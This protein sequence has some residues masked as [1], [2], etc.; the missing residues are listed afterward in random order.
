[1][2]FTSELKFEIEIS[3]NVIS[4]GNDEIVFDYVG[5]DMVTYGKQTM[6]RKIYHA[7]TVDSAS[8]VRVLVVHVPNGNDVFIPFRLEGPFAGRSANLKQASGFQPTPSSTSTLATFQDR[9]PATILSRMTRC[10]DLSL[11]V[12]HGPESTAST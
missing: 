4:K 5:S 7:K 10:N 8:I 2:I 6:N 9:R 1:M 12:L 3:I 11:L